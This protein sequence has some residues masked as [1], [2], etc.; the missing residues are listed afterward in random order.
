MVFYLQGGVVA[1]NSDLGSLEI[2]PELMMYKQSM[3]YMPS[4]NMVSGLCLGKKQGRFIDALIQQ[5]ILE[6]LVMAGTF[7]STIRCNLMGRKPLATCP[8]PLHL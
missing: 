6:H 1:V 4:H 7:F 3:L 8:N 5:I 2:F